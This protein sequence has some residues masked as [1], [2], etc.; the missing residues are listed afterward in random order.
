MACSGAYLLRCRLLRACLPRFGRRGPS[1][2]AALLEYREWE[3]THGATTL[4]F[5]S[6]ITGAGADTS[7]T[8]DEIIHGLRRGAANASPLPPFWDFYSDILANQAT[9]RA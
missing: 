5:V 8:V 4:W 7:V 3:P 1:S 2:F 9:P 6:K